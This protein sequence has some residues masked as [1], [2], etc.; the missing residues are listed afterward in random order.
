LR[1]RTKRRLLWLGALVLICF[2]LP[3]YGY[4]RA[5]LRAYTNIHLSD[6]TDARQHKPVFDADLIFRDAAGQLLALGKSDQ[7]YGV[8]RFNHPQFGSC[9]S[10]EA[11]ATRS[12]AG[13]GLWDECIG[14]MFRWQAGWAPKVGAMD[15]RFAGCGVD[16]IPLT[17]RMHRDDWWL[18][19]V[20][21][22]HI[23]GD[24][25]TQ[26]SATVNVYPE[27]CQVSVAGH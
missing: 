11:A 26:F 19:W 24:P 6:V 2:A 9:E 15:I 16:K 23:G 12:A 5:L 3:S 22:P 21:L 20:P 7:R 10:E 27:T 25:I 18:W 8:V 14:A 1:R 17:L 4:R 13:R